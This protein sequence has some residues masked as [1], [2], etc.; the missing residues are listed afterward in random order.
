MSVCLSVRISTENIE[1]ISFMNSI[2]KNFTENYR[3]I[4]IS[5]HIDPNERITYV[6][7]QI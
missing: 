6:Q 2:W 4:L 3:K 7:E 5:R 1:K